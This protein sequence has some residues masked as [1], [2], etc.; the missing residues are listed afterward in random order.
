MLKSLL[1][2]QKSMW[3]ILQLSQ[4]DT[5]KKIVLYLSKSFAIISSRTRSPP[6][7]F[8]GMSRNASIR[9]A[10]RDAAQHQTRVAVICNL[11]MVRLRKY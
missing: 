2:C 3:H 6:L 8:L 4:G 7:L 9:K 10:W 5:V 11:P 1:G